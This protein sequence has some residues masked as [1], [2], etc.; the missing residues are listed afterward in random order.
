MTH[1]TWKDMLDVVDNLDSKLQIVGWYHTHP[2]DLDV[3]MSGTDTATQA[4]VF[5]HDWQFAI[6]LNPHKKIWRSFYGANSNECQ[7]Y[8]IYFDNTV[9]NSNNLNKTDKLDD[10]DGSTKDVESTNQKKF[11]FFIGIVANNVNPYS[12]DI[13]I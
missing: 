4:R 9:D 12:Y 11:Y 5:S 13:P 6:V 7:G 2:N 8:V 1:E 10:S 3:F